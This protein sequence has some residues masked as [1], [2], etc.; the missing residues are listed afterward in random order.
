MAT[1]NRRIALVSARLALLTALV[2][3]AASG[4]VSFIARGEFRA[5]RNP[6]FVAVGDFNGDGLLD[7]AVAN[8]R[9]E[10]VSVLLGNG[11]GSFQAA[12][13]FEAGRAPSSVVVGDFDGDGVQDLAVANLAFQQRLGTFGER[14]WKLPGRPQLWGRGRPNIRGGRRLQ[15]RQ[16]SRFGRGQRRARTA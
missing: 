8:F 6:H 9:S 10:T 16:P 5:G 3:T 15:W 2:T 14:G 13:N 12:R 1:K 11:D 7:L 4:E